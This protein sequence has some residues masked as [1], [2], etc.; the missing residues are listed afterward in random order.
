MGGLHADV[1][2]TSG[3][4][5]FYAVGARADMTPAQFR[6]LPD[7]GGAE[8]GF[9]V[10][11]PARLVARDDL[12]RAEVKLF[13]EVAGVLQLQ[14]RFLVVSRPICPACEDFLTKRGTT[15]TSAT[16]AEW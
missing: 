16:T 11:Q 15:L 13:N 8:F 9:R 1:P 12:W 14:P 6:E 5:D 10:P 4:L 2:G 7:L 3:G